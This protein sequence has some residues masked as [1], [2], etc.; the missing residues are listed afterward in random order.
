M[1]DYL[2]Q[3]NA[4]SKQYDYA[5]NLYNHYPKHNIYVMIS[6]IKLSFVYFNDFVVDD[7]YYIDMLNLD[8]DIDKLSKTTKKIMLYFQGNM[9][10]LKHD[11]VKI[12]KPNYD[13]Y[14]NNGSYGIIYK[15]ND[16]VIK[17]MKNESAYIEIACLKLL[18]HNNII[19]LHH[20]DFDKHINLYL[21]YYQFNLYELLL[22][23]FVPQEKHFNQLIDAVN[24]C[25]N[26]DIIHRDIKCENIM[27]DEKQD[28]LILID[29][30]C[31]L[32]YASKREYL[33]CHVGSLLTRAPEMLLGKPYTSKIDIWS[34][35]LVFYMMKNHGDYLYTGYTQ[36][37]LLANIY[38][39]NIKDSCLM[40]NPEDR[41]FKKFGEAKIVL[42][43]LAT[44]EEVHM[45]PLVNS[46]GLHDFPE[47]VR[48]KLDTYFDEILHPDYSE[49]DEL[50]YQLHMT[51]HW[52][53][54]IFNNYRSVIKI[55]S[56]H[57]NDN[58]TD[59]TK[60]YLDNNGI[61]FDQLK[62]YKKLLSDSACLYLKLFILSTTS[63]SEIEEAAYTWIRIAYQCYNIINKIKI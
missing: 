44:H 49:V 8:M 63:I 37:E 28:K 59:Y 13:N 23:G 42:K 6:C 19:E 34:M 45:H 46:Y 18:S 53:L 50:L 33:S 38:K 17:N 29:F 26:H 9:L 56:D 5:L 3:L 16:Y 52:S 35:G 25:H 57:S 24:H 60:K 48:N 21:P 39:I 30:G 20:F 14:I 61:I 2:N 27:Y 32:T 58:K 12:Y 4:S 36:E 7:G 47:I 54:Q 55:I 51:V 22:N 40:I 1:E 43:M 15:V 31:A 11:I 62:E 10:N 41:K